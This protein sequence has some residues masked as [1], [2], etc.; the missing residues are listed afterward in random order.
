M[1]PPISANDHDVLVA[2]ANDMSWVKAGL[3]G[4]LALTG[5][6]YVVG[7]KKIF[8]GGEVKNRAK[9][10]FLFLLG[11]F[12]LAPVSFALAGTLLN[13]EVDPTIYVGING[14]LAYGMTALW[15]KIA[16]SINTKYAP[17]V[18]LGTGL[19]ASFVWGFGQGMNGRQIL[20]GLLSGAVAMTGHDLLG[21]IGAGLQALGIK[22]KPNGPR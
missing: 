13:V 12:L 11:A 5:G 15:K 18:S 17:L 3:T 2:L 7:L 21:T 9:V 16:P 14:A 1:T 20:T 6:L 4:Q 22:P 8:G 19:A 10:F